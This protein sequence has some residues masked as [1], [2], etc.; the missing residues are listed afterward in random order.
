MGHWAVQPVQC[1]AVQP[2]LLCSAQLCKK[3]VVSLN[4]ILLAEVGLV[5]SLF[6]LLHFRIQ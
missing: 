4:L 2:V 3:R 6:N 1:A 5:F